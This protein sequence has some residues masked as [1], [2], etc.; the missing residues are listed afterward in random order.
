MDQ[1]QD[2]CPH[3]GGTDTAVGMQA[4]QARV[5]HK[6]AITLFGGQDLF[7]VICLTCGTV[8]RSFVKH[9]EKLT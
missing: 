8:V 1:K 2:I 3:C 6:D 7:H 9:P 4:A 5:I